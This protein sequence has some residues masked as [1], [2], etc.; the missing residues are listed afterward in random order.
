M[1]EAWFTYACSDTV[2][3]AM[4]RRPCLRICASETKKAQNTDIMGFFHGM[5]DAIRTH[6]LQSR[7]LTL[8]PAELRVRVGH[9]GSAS[10]KRIA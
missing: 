7:S 8:Y 1:Q 2:R 6:G 9:M 5:P 4:N 3:R 10:S